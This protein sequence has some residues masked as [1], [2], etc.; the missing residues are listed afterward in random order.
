[1][2][3]LL[4]EKALREFLIEDLGTGDMSTSTI[5]DNY[6]TQ[7]VIH[8]KADGL[9]CGLDIAKMVF[10]ILDK[11]FKFTKNV[12]EGSYVERGTTLATVEGKAKVILQGERLALN[13]LQRLSAVATMTNTYQKKIDKYGVY[14]TDTRKTTPGL[15][16]F[17]KYAVQTGGGK[18]HRFGLYD[19]IMLKDNHI[20]IAG[21]ISKAVEDVKKITPHTMKV[22]VE[23]ESIE[24]VK[25]ALKSGA[26]I[27]MLDNMSVEMMVQAVN[28]I[29]KKALVEASGGITLETIEEVAK[30]GVNY[31][32]VGALTHS[33]KSMDIS[34]DMFNKKG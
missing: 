10:Q 11:D 34:L 3:Q 22:E 26:D 7:A 4:I 6:V 30:T 24:Q 31:I 17:E 18:N 28:L 23:V 16:I 29:D 8:A 19:A 5:D 15:R 13:L 2:N 1:M 25:E 14:V 12:E 9:I 33:Y 27:I 21:S 32:S 20:K